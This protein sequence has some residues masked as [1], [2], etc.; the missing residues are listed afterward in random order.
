MR[1]FSWRLGKGTG[2]HCY[3]IDWRYVGEPEERRHLW[4]ANNA[5][6]AVQATRN[7]APEEVEIVNVEEIG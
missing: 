6:E 2:M 5:D 7:L 4:D 1:D 3:Q